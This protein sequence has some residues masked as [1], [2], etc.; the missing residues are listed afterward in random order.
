[1][2]GYIR[3]IKIVIIVGWIQFEL[4]ELLVFGSKEFKE[5]RRF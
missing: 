4:I 3:E 5:E 1:M 2:A